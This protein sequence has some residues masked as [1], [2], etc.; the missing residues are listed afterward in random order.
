MEGLTLW[1]QYI[2]T[3]EALIITTD[4]ETDDLIALYIM[5]KYIKDMPKLIIV[6]EGNSQIKYC[7]MLIYSY[8]LGFT[9]TTIIKGHSSHQKFKCDGLDILSNEAIT[10]INNSIDQTDPID[11]IRLFIKRYPDQTIISLKPMRELLEIWKEEPDIFANIT[12]IGYMGFNV[13]SIMNNREQDIINFFR[14]FKLVIYYETFLA[15]G[16]KNNI[17]EADDF[18]FDKLPNFITKLMKSWNTN[19]IDKCLQSIHIK[20]M[21]ITHN[22]VDS[23]DIS[24][25][26]KE[27]LK[28]NIK[29]VKNIIESN[30]SQFVNADSGLIASLLVPFDKSYCYKGSLSF[31]ATGY[32]VPK[33]DPLGN[34]LFINPIS[35]T[36]KALLLTFQHILYK[37]IFN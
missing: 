5:A 15:T 26:N 7:R 13:R 23:L 29:I 18:P 9:N 32:S 22:D 34:I 10:E 4:L 16:S 14:S 35:N 24:I 11:D 3:A 21:L 30:Y 31:S 12:L 17:D 8:L 37:Y 19:M 28:R 2:E 6:G 1:N 33:A 36:D 27:G 20:I 25:K